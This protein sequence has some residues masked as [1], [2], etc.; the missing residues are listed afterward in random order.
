MKRGIALDGSWTTDAAQRAQS[1]ARIARQGWAATEAECRE[2]KPLAI[3]PARDFALALTSCLHQ[4]NSGNFVPV[5]G[6]TESNIDLYWPIWPLPP[7]WHA[8]TWNC[9]I[10]LLN[11][12]L[13]GEAL[14]FVSLAP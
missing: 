6:S 12:D 3:S 7:Q 4:S 2:Q 8:L 11:S 1:L 5:M 10:S 9:R 13:K 14:Q